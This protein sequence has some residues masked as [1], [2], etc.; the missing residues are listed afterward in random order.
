MVASIVG[1]GQNVEDCGQDGKGE[2][3]AIGW[4]GF[5]GS[6]EVLADSGEELV[7]IW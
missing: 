7:E 5:Y 6:G 4:G 1:R 3:G 2:A